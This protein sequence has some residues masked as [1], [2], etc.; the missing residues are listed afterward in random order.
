M[1]RG[2]ASLAILLIG[3]GALASAEEQMTVYRCEAAGKVTLQDEPCPAG[4]SQSTRSMVRPKDPPP[5]PAARPADESDDRDDA[6]LPPP[7]PV[8]DVF[9][10]PP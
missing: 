2:R 8:Y 6:D 10:P 7:E 9:P 5:R 1:R 3:V 4:A